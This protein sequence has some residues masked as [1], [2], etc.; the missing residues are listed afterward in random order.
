[1]NERLGIPVLP[2][3][4]ILAVRLTPFFTAPVCGPHPVVFQNIIK[5]SQAEAK[6]RDGL[7]LSFLLIKKKGRNFSFCAPPAIGDSGFRVAEAARQEG[8]G[9]ARIGRH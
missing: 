5:I 8:P 7:F 3:T 1:L 9:A 4:D 6:H 2:V